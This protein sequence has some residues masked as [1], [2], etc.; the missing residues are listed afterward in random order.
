[1]PYEDFPYGI[2]HFTE[3]TWVIQRQ[4]PKSIQQDLRQLEAVSQ[5]TIE[6]TSDCASVMQG[7]I[8]WVRVATVGID[9]HW[10]LTVKHVIH[11]EVDE[12]LLGDFVTN[13]QFSGHE[14]SDLAIVLAINAITIK[15][16]RVRCLS[17]LAI[18]DTN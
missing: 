2:L 6:C 15:P 8:H 5:T 14:R 3:E 17:S 10:R 13:N 18:I 9:I 7:R 16:R 12:Q 1:M 11:V 4:Q